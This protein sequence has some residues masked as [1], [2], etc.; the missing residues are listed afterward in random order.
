[1]KYIK[2]LVAAAAVSAVL[3]S[4]QDVFT[5]SVFESVYVLDYDSMSNEQ[6]VSYAEG[7]LA[8]GSEEELE[9]AYAEIAE[10]L[11]GVDLNSSELTEEDVELIELAADLAIGASGVGDAVTDALGA[12]T[13]TDEDADP[14]A[15]AEAILGGF[16]DSDYESLESAV[17]L[18]AAAENNGAE[19]TSEQ[20]TNAAAAQLLVVINE[21]DGAD[22]STLD[23]NDP[24]AQDLE[25][26]LA[27]ADAG[28]LDPSLFGEGFAR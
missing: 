11:E 5:T 24:I 28:G 15:A 19:L 13:S 1:M 2:L 25:Q 4:C 18:V 23:E 22:P 9:A 14:A 8:T 27:W 12:F 3:L 17:A 7:L 20:Y 16:D 6:K 10:M 26:A 21:L